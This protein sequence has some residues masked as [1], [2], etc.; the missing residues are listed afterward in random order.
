MADLTIEFTWAVSDSSRLQIGSGLSRAGYA[1]SC[2]PLD[3]DGLLS[4]LGGKAKGAIRQSAESLFRWLVA[5]APE[6]SNDDSTSTP[7]PGAVFRIFQSSETNKFWRF[8]M[9]VF[10]SD[11][12]FPTTWSNT[13]IDHESGVA[14]TDTLRTKESWD[15]GAKIAMRISAFNLSV[16][17]ESKDWFDV[18]FLLMAI[19]STEQIGGGRGNGMGEVTLDDITVSDGVVDISRCADPETLIALQKHLGATV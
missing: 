17:P 7:P 19:A 3:R 13:A 16:E 4:D 12:G 15:N 6:E 10:T 14:R 18:L 9:P 1:D 11:A 2:L 5:N 8:D